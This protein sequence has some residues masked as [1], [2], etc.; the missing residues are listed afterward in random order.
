MQV[1]DI[2][3]LKYPGTLVETHRLVR[4]VA[5]KPDTKGRVR[6]VR[7]AYRQKKAR[8]KKEVCSTK[9]VEEEEVVSA[10]SSWGST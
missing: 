4:V 6:T 2:C 9:L 7:V 3:Q 10:T 8:E 5:V 1:G